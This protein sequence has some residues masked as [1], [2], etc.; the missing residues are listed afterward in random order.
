MCY[1]DGKYPGVVVMFRNLIRPDNFLMVT[2][3]MI[4]DCIF[5]SLFWVLGCFPVVTMGA[6]FAALYDSAVASFRR[7]ERD[8][9]QRFIGTFRQN[10]KGG[11]LPTLV[12]LAS[13]ALMAWGLIQVWNGAVYGVI[14]WAAF[15]AAALVAVL[16]IGVVSVLFPMLSRFENS[17]G[18]LLRNTVLL[19]LGNM[20]RTLLLGVI[21]SAV[22][23]ICARFVFPLFFLPAPAALLGSFLLEPMFKPYMPKGDAAE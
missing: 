5:L 8:S 16:V 23:Y 20:P 15:S 19:A 18:A 12:F 4:T 10:L 17:L 1:N 9:W 22:I 11:I 3:S 14:P 2:M 7:R 21:N 13:L 6:S